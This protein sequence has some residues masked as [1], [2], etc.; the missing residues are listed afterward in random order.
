MHEES[1]FW[2]H[3]VAPC[4]SG[5]KPGTVTTATPSKILARTEL[6][7]KTGTP[8]KCSDGSAVIPADP[9]T[10]KIIGGKSVYT[11]AS[12]KT[13]TYTAATPSYPLYP[14]TAE[15]NGWTAAM[16]LDRKDSVGNVKPNPTP[17]PCGTDDP[18]NASFIPALGGTG[19]NTTGTPSGTPATPAVT[20]PVNLIGGAPVGAVKPPVACTAGS[21]GCTC[22]GSVCTAPAAGTT[23]AVAC[24]AGTPGCVCVTTPAGQVCTKPSVT[25]TCG[26]LPLQPCPQD[27]KQ[28][29]TGRLSW[30]ELIN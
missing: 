27:P 11:P 2:H 18:H 19:G 9:L 10:C 8:A 13:G 21:A 14:V 30:H 7:A 4:M 25:P 24:V 5:V 23:T 6:A 17:R 22:V 16:P 1:V 28:P 12:C 20:V 3:D 29:R 15:I 26:S